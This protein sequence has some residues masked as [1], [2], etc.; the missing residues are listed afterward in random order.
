MRATVITWVAPVL[1]AWAAA[2]R[3]RSMPVS[4]LSGSATSPAA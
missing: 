2:P 4:G 3:S 1:S